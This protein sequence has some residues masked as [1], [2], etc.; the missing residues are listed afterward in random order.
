MPNLLNNKFR[1]TPANIEKVSILLAEF[2]EER[3]F[4]NKAGRFLFDLIE[5]CNDPNYVVHT[6]HLGVGIDVQLPGADIPR[7]LRVNG[8]VKSVGKFLR[9][10]S[11]TVEGNVQEYVGLD[12]DNGEILVK[13]NVLERNGSVG[14]NMR[15]GIITIEG[16]VASAIVGGAMVNG[17]ITIKGNCKGRIGDGMRG[18]EIHLEGDYGTIGNVIGGKIYHKGKLIVD[19]TDS[20]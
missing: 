6:T 10:G 20:Q 4:S 8:S 19:A 7:N 18:G 15:D 12:M 16:D 9:Q 14:G 5:R 11:I 3:N 1:Y 13:G 17:R 2:E